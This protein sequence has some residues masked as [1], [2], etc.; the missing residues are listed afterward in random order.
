MGKL[1][2]E[3]LIVAD[4]IKLFILLSMHE[5]RAWYMMKLILHVRKKNEGLN[6]NRHT[7]HYPEIKDCIAHFTEIELDRMKTS[8]RANY[9]FLSLTT[10]LYIFR[11][12]FNHLPTISIFL[13]ILRFLFLFFIMVNN[14]F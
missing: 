13:S 6:D 12:I 5:E 14:I 11:T 3:L 7:Q 9:L 10:E 4:D 1:V 8:N 2:I